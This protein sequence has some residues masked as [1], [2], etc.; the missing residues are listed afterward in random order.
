M[1]RNL[2][3]AVAVLALL[4]AAVFA[5]L[6]RS[7]YSA[8]RQAETAA[9]YPEIAQYYLTAAR[10]LPWEPGLYE[11][12]GTTYYH[13]QDYPNAQ[14]AYQMA[15]ERNALSAEG[16]VA[17][18]DVVYLQDDPA[19]ALQLWQEGLARPGFS[20]QLYS[21]LAKIH[22]ERRE[23]P[24][25]AQN[26]K[27]YVAA[28]PDDASARYRLGL[29]LTL[30]EP[31]NAIP[32]LLRASELDP[33]FDPVAQT[34]RTAL[35]LAS[36]T[37][38]ASERFVI[39]GRGLG[40]VNEWELALAAFEQAVKEDEENAEAWAWLA[41]AN[42]QT[43]GNDALTLLD[44]ALQLDPASST[45]HSLRG[46]YFQRTGNHR[47][48]LTEFQS[49][50][51]LDVENPSLFVSLGDAYA[52][53]GDL[54]R[55]LQA[56]QYAV[57]LA[58]DDVNYRILLAS[59]CAENNVNLGDVGIP[60]AQKAVQME[61]KNSFALDVLGWSY[62]LAGRQNE[63]ERMLVLAVEHDPQNASAH[64]HLG[65]VYLQRNERAQAYEQLTRARDLG[66]MEA[67]AALRQYFPQ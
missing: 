56:Y 42:Q 17:W 48:A 61:P 32:E 53:T 30:L 45:V 25:A 62:S 6:V 50:A 2:V 63:A 67:D 13:A 11:L 36:I 31:E 38:S 54:I 33:Q 26:L 49:A 8:W 46:L 35:N 29:L 3:R 22:Q 20:P 5:P 27:E 59:F 34:L 58:P 37:D 15:A 64:F 14:A 43:A 52:M 40:L 18:G 55:G 51:R 7:G 41:E 10:R 39:L 23:Y 47:D 60:A 57:E 19:R 21:R 66:S 12:A 65:V 44:R 1:T 24:A 4:L 28:Q 9:T 16:W